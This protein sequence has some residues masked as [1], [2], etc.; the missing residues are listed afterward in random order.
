MLTDKNQ[1]SMPHRWWACVVLVA[2]MFAPAPLL[3][4]P[5]GEQTPTLRVR[6]VWASA[7]PVRWAGRLSITD[8]ELAE[9][10]LLGRERDTPGSIWT[11]NGQVLIAQPRP[12]TFDGFDVT[13]R[14]SLDATLQIELRADG[15]EQANLVEIPLTE[16][17]RDTRRSTL[18]SG[19]G[20]TS[21]T[22]VV[23]RLADDALRVDLGS[24]SRVFKP[25]ETLRM[26]VE[27]ALPDLEAGGSIDL[28]TE[29]FRGR[30]THRE[31]EHTTRVSLPTEG[32]AQ[33]PVEVPLPMVD[34]V[35]TIR[36]T[37]STPPGNR[38]RFWE[39][40]TGTKLA[41]RTFQVVVLGDS[42]TEHYTG[43]TWRTTVEIDPAN[44]KWYTRLTEWTRLDRL[45]NL[46]NGPLGSE[47]FR[48]T[49]MAGRTL[50]ELSAS[51]PER[52]TWQ[53]Y[54]L[55]AAQPGRPHVVE[56]ELPTGFDQQ[57]A[58]RVYEYNSAGKLVPNG[59]GR[60]VVVEQNV[61]GK[62][63]PSTEN[64]RYLF[65]PR[66]RSPVVVI[67]NA[68]DDTTGRYGRIRLRVAERGRGEPPTLED[69]GRMVAASYGWQAL[70][71]RTNVRSPNADGRMPVD[72][73]ETF[74]QLAERAAALLELSGYNGA[75]VGVMD[76]GSAAF[77]LGKGQSLPLLDTSCLLGGA[78]DLP[79]VNPTDLMLR[80][81]S[82]R[83][84][85]LVPSL[86]LNATLP[87]IE[88]NIRERKYKVLDDFP[89]WTD[90]AGR[91]RSVVLPE[92]PQVQ[93]WHYRLS[94]PDV[95]AQV[96]S[97]AHRLAEQCAEHP[98]FAGVA[99]NFSAD[100]YVACPP[101]SYGLTSGRIAE[102]AKATGA[103][104]ATLEVW[105][106]DPRELL[107]DASTMQ[108]WK[109]RR[110]AE[111]TSVLEQLASD[112]SEVRPDAKLWIE[113]SELL[114]TRELDVRPELLGERPLDEI[115]LERG[116]DVAT[117]RDS[118]GIEL[119][120]VWHQTTGLELVDAA[121]A[122]ALNERTPVQT[123]NSTQGVVL[124]HRTA[125]VAEPRA[126]EFVAAR[127][128]HSAMTF[129]HLGSEI[130]RPIAASV[131]LDG[132]GPLVMG[133]PIGPGCLADD[134]R[135]AMLE[136]LAKLPDD[137]V[138]SE[139]V[140]IEQPVIARVYRSADKAVAMATNDS[141]WPV[142]ATVT[143][144]VSERTTATRI[145]IDAQ[146]DS[147]NLYSEGPHAWSLKLA[148]YESQALRFES[149]QVKASGVRVELDPSIQQ[150]LAA[151]C[152]QLESRDLKPTSLAT[153]RAML[154][155]SFEE[156]D[157]AGVAVGWQGGE[158]VKTATPGVDGTR[159]AV[160]ES[161]GSAASIVTQPFQTPSTGQIELSAQVKVVQ[162]SD[163][164]QLS[165]I[166]EDSGRRSLV[167]LTAK[168]LKQ[169][170]S[171][172]EWNK[173]QFGVENL[174]L[175]STA[176]MRIRIE[177]TGSGEVWIDDLKLHSLVYP[178]DVYPESNQKVLALVQHVKSARRALES[179]QYGDC[180]TILDSYWSRFI[181][182]HLPEIE[183]PPT[184]TIA[185][186]EAKPKEPE[187]TPRLSERVKDWFRF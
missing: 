128:P 63:G 29:L 148:P 19:A 147:P 123:G 38:S 139:S 15:Q 10:A 86:R 46:G 160:L 175:D 89:V 49:N 164:A 95:A 33:V 176:E 179:R 163:D 157:T 7:A 121:R 82:R 141:P 9:V 52:P 22:L 73:L 127:S 60:G 28:A 34:G 92:L 159:A 182:E 24:D 144:D 140:S 62:D 27:P 97:I 134:R 137:G 186:A 107:K 145:S 55:P 101:S 21:T 143:L 35:Y 172:K 110:A 78:T 48:T 12:R 126:S 125:P 57:L 98:A 8:G 18:S 132:G 26:Q 100:S 117:L 187:S 114:E 47:E 149:N 183:T 96:Q 122:L 108:V 154:N 76:G 156:I 169:N 120:A 155:P 85:R 151:R 90:L 72:D 102:L 58:I 67:E 45:T 1:N 167:P 71:D 119:A 146:A 111:V 93:P 43:G 113:V 150:A 44:P 70:V 162:L 130:G 56:V 80:I 168:Q 165:L 166:V 105:Q 77:D 133:G 87:A 138:Q 6:V 152:E 54:P 131:R 135:R 41:E 112:V 11:E 174:S 153:Y 178:M 25:G 53:A 181:L 2:T 66:S 136:L 129:D 161:N 30:G 74:Y 5:P 3:A 88:A 177:L 109:A 142:S 81:F 39:T 23:H 4:A 115:H 118:A 68:R 17:M 36:L 61:A 106:S 173:Y 79:V 94:H 50:A 40:A 32:Y 13:A 37:A 91:A 180:L 103:Q 42:T 31:W 124:W 116:I 51:R 84:L 99:I 16:L 83:G 65:W 158:G 69:R 185:P 75:V 104:Q 184:A 14:A 170:S 59:P 64:C 20:D 171:A